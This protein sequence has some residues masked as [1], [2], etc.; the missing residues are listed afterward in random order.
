VSPERTALN[1]IYF[2]NSIALD[3]DARLPDI[4][5][6]SCTEDD[7]LRHEIVIDAFYSITCSDPL[8]TEVVPTLK[9]FEAALLEKFPFE[10]VTSNL[11][12]MRF[13]LDLLEVAT[14]S[15]DDD[16]PAPKHVDGIIKHQY[17]AAAKRFGLTYIRKLKYAQ[18]KD[19]TDKLYPIFVPC[20]SRKTKYIADIKKQLEKDFA[21][22]LHKS[23]TKIG[24]VACVS[25]HAKNMVFVTQEIERRRRENK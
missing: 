13:R 4:E 24:F 2:R 12:Y 14:E 8:Y 19:L 17:L 22:I 16:D 7:V 9:E 23:I 11:H 5:Y 1:A 18:A 15:P 6:R 25:K 3:Q 20:N 21:Y 10:E